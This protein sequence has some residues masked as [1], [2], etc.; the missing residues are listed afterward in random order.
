MENN[1]LRRVTTVIAVTVFLV[2]MAVLFLAGHFS[3]A[4]DTRSAEIIV[5]VSYRPILMSGLVL[6]LAIVVFY[7]QNRENRL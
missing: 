1:T 6:A 3:A 2:A 7:S 5:E 4:G